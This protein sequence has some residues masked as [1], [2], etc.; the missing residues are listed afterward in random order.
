MGTNRWSDGRDVMR[1]VIV[2]AGMARLSAAKGL[3][4][5]GSGVEVFEQATELKPLGASV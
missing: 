3:Q 4:I 1:A 5:L 2:G